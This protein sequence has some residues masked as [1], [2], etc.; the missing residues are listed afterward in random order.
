MINLYNF[1]YKIKSIEKLEN[2]NLK[3]IILRIQD[4]K[5]FV[6]KVFVT[7][8]HNIKLYGSPARE[9]PPQPAPEPL[10]PR[11]LGEG[12]RLAF[13]FGAKTTKAAAAKAEKPKKANIFGF[14]PEEEE[15]GE[16]AGDKPKGGGVWAPVPPPPPPNARPLRLARSPRRGSRTP[17]TPALR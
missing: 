3:S 16:G 1:K 8:M 4:D 11:R 9:E 15:D 12:P 2:F 14:E 7:G 13:S 10:A 6:S 5:K 17:P